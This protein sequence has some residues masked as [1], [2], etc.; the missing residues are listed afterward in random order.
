MTSGNPTTRTAQQTKRNEDAK[1]R[2]AAKAAEAAAQPAPPIE[3]APAQGER[4]VDVGAVLAE[5]QNRNSA[6]TQENI[7]LTV[8]N[9]ALES[10]LAE[11]GVS[12]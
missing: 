9:R 5:Y 4:S 7:I 8:R 6:L 11:A 2:R 10:A 1:A 3:Q 12:A